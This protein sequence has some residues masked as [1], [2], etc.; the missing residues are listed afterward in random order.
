MVVA[1]IDFDMAQ[2][3]ALCRRYGVARLEVFGSMARG[4]GGVESDLDLLYELAP[5]ATL[6]WEIEDL[7]AAERLLRL[8]ERR[9]VDD[10][11]EPGETRQPSP[12]VLVVRTGRLAAA[13]V[14]AWP[15]HPHGRHPSGLKYPSRNHT[16]PVNTPL[17]VPLGGTCGGSPTGRRDGLG[18]GAT[19]VD[20]VGERGD[21]HPHGPADVDGFDIALS[22][23]R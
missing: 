20:E 12:A 23:R 10:S 14:H 16:P 11:A 2:L 17:Q 1:G 22:M 21:G 15:R 5:G 13:T 18:G 9:S 8:V 4:E 6:G 3:D 7:E 19:T